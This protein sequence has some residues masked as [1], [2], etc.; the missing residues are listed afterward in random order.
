MGIH[1]LVVYNHAFDL[2]LKHSFLWQ[3]RLFRKLYNKLYDSVF[4]MNKKTVGMKQINKIL[5][6]SEL[7]MDLLEKIV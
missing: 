7:R 5:N 3:G 2:S 4:R 1:E 6:N